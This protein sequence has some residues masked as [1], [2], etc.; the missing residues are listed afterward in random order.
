MAATQKRIIYRHIDLEGW[1]ADIDCYMKDGG[2]EVLKS[3]VARPRE[4]LCAE[5]E[6]SKIKGRGGAGFPMGMKWKFLDR[7]SGKPIYLVCNA[8]ESEPGTCKDRPLIYQ[9]PHQIIEGIMCA[10]Y[11]VN[12]AH[13]FIYIRG[14]YINGYRILQNAVDEAKAKGFVGKN[15][16][17]S[18][19]SCEITICRGGGCYVCGEETGLLSSLAGGRGYPRIKPPYFPAVMGLYDCPTVVNNVESLCW[20]PQ[21]FKLGGEAVSKIG[22]PVD[23]GT[24]VW[25]VSGQVQKPGRY[26][27]ETGSCKLGE[28]LYD[29]CGGPLAGRT[30][31][32]IIPGGSS[33]KI[34]KWGEKFN[35][36]R[37]D[38]TV[39]EL[40]VED[41][42]MD[43]ASFM[44]C[45]TAIG[46][47][48]MI[49]MDNTVDMA[50]ALANLNAF[51][52]HESCGQCTPCREGSLWISRITKRIC[53]GW[54]RK[55]DIDLLLDIADNI[56]GRTICAHGESVA[57]PVQSN[58]GKFREEYLSKIERQDM[59]GGQAR[60]DNNSYR[61]I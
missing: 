56:C 11:A 8:D 26:E 42:P 48:G 41:I 58:V 34:L 49:V 10:S 35:V 44:S 22:V 23:P 45:G 43:S 20:V 4:E 12:A 39:E 2:Y 57:W 17:G 36:K 21:I 7:K 25:G 15:V 24:H 6:K 51:Y 13:A 37:P 38:G 52:A 31:K 33:M 59:M 50:E 54:G 16:C 9:D 14:E 32:A 3:A 5:V 30:F 19:Y 61:L 1:S 27:I 18:D 40:R 55:E 47:C 53:D 60:L 29:I 46:S 28:F